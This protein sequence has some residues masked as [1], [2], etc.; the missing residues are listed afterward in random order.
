M[1][2]RKPVSPE[3][4]AAPIAAAA[5]SG[6]G[7]AATSASGRPAVA[8]DVPQQFVAAR[9]GPAGSTLVYRA[10]LL[11]A[12][13]IRFTDAKRGIDATNDVRYL[14]PIDDGPL[15]IQWDKAEAVTFPLA[16]LEKEPQSG[17]AFEPLPPAAAKAKSYAGWKSDFAAWLF[18][19]ATLDLRQ[20]GREQRDALVEK[21]R[22][23]YAPKVQRLEEKIRTAQQA[24]DRES[25]QARAAELQ[26]A[27]SVGATVLGALLGRKRISSTSLGRA[28][29][30]ARGVGRSIQQQ[31]DVGRAKEDVA[32]AQ[33]ELAALNA[34]LEQKT[35]SLTDVAIRPTK[36][37]I[38]VQA[39]M[40]AWAPYWRDAQ[41]S[42][43]PAWA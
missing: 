17:A 30:A 28:T 18:R 29:T 7:A 16:D 1:A 8:P 13:K 39:V 5:D 42:L 22:A 37:N 34:E 6:A 41:G 12:A 19:V 36:S 25:G 38:D 20:A 14:A 2:G 26:T 31:Q 4:A 9:G 32:S 15:G 33:A 27:V 23:E 40:L 10:R 43:A 21:L 24:V 3:S 11:A 35:G